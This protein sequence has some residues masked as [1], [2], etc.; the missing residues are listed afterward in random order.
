[1]ATKKGTKKPKTCPRCGMPMHAGS[2]SMK[3]R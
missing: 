1:M 2:C 3:K